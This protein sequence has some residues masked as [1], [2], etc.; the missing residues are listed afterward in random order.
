[1]ESASL[2]ALEDLVQ[3]HPCWC[4]GVLMRT[5]EALDDLAQISVVQPSYYDLFS[6]NTQVV[7]YRR[8]LH[9]MDR[10][11]PGHTASQTEELQNSPAC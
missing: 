8:H 3:R 2:W 1:M 11:G 10:D 6:W 7:G 9:R 4:R 5:L